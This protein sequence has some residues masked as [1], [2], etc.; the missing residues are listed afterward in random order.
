MLDI[1]HTRSI[2]ACAGEPIGQAEQQL[3]D[4]V[5]PRVCGGTL[6]EKH[7]NRLGVGLSPR[8]R[9]NLQQ[10]RILKHRT[11]SIPA[12]AGEPNRHCRALPA[13][14]VYPRVCGGTRSSRKDEVRTGG[15]SPRVRGN[16]D[17]RGTNY[18][19]TGSIPACAGEP[20]A[21]ST[22]DPNH[23]VYPRVCGGTSPYQVCR[24]PLEPLSPRVRGNQ[25]QWR[26]QACRKRSIP[27]CAGEPAMTSPNRRIDR[28]YPRVCGGTHLS[29]SC[30]RVI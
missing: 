4:E 3:L 21:D 27:A 1:S 24:L 2:P 28:V 17:L 5:Y 26:L 20:T 25:R 7:A 14:R 19:V 29:F 10:D 16:R 23:K 8:V 9:G 11:G 15:L 18:G 22:W 6:V 13:T 12:C 30:R